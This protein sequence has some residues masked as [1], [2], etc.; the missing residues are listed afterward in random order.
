MTAPVTVG[1]RRGRAQ[2]TLT[3]EYY[4]MGQVSKFVR[5]G[6]VRVASTTL[7][8]VGTVAFRNP[9]GSMVLVV[10]NRRARR[11]HVEVGVASR[12]SF[13]GGLL[14]ADCIATYVWNAP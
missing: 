12:E 9:D 1:G 3:R 5:P 7:P 11:L 4:E 6:A 8:A 2:F 10:H 14:P 13:D